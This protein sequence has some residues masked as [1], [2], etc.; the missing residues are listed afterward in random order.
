MLKSLLGVSSTF[1]LLS[2]PA[3]SFDA[4]TTFNTVC[5][6][7][8]SAPQG[9]DFRDKRVAPPAFAVKNHYIEHFKD[10]A[11]FVKAMVRFLMNPTKE[12]SLM[13]NAVAKF[14]LMNKLPYTEDQYKALASYLYKQ[15]FK[16]PGGY[17]KHRK[18]EC[19]KNPQRCEMI[20]QRVQRIRKEL[21]Q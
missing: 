1:L 20:K 10:E 5:A 3:F 4:A 16:R 11:T 8:H 13:P 19:A 9:P 12:E 17:G 18:E 6:T 15:E 14:G 21:S 2:A 7:C